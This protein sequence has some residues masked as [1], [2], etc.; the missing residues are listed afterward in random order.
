MPTAA[1]YARK[2]SESDD[3]QVLSLSSQIEWARAVCV[4]LGVSAP[5]VLEEAMSAKTPGRP[6]FG[7]LMDLI[8]RG[9]VDTVV[10]WKAD[11]LARNALDGGAIIYTL[12]A[13]KLTQIV[14]ADRL[15]TGDG[16]SVLMLNMELG[17]SAKYSKDLAKNIRR[18][19][20]EKLRRGEWSGKAPL[21]YRNVRESADHGK[22]ETDP[23]MALVIKELFRLAASGTVS[24][25]KLAALTRD[26]WRLRLTK[27]RGGVERVGLPPSCL[28]RILTNPFYYGAMRYRGQLHVGTHEPL[29]SHDLFDAVQTAFAGRRTLSERPKRKAFALAGLIRCASCGRRLSGVEKVKRSGRRY[30]YYVCSKHQK[31]ACAQ[32]PVTEG[33]V[34]ATLRLSLRKLSITKP[35]LGIVERVLAERERTWAKRADGQ[36]ERLEARRAGVGKQ[37]ARLLDLLVSGTVAES[38]YDR[39]ARELAE[40]EARATLALRALDANPADELEPVRAFFRGLVDLPE[41]FDAGEAG[42][43]RALV[44]SV[45]LELEAADEELRVHATQPTAQLL[46]RRGRALTWRLVDNVVNSLSS[47]T[48]IGVIRPPERPPGTTG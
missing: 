45:G 3:R 18:G 35:D 37:R 4:K 33:A 47:T 36:R 23:E 39:K 30:T 2:S 14:T 11:R 38:D 16:D 22:I 31:G 48:S 29:V 9:A 24:L 34:L 10:C 17:L 27:R 1:I 5:L 19:I 32:R 41:S 46:R 13:K 6:V 42:E 12:E 7:Q 25:S 44:R 20:D 43:R 15:Y 40:E 8:Q 28:H 21:G 26:P